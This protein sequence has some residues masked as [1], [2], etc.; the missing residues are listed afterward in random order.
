MSNQAHPI[1]RAKFHRVI[2]IA[3]LTLLLVGACKKPGSSQELKTDQDKTLYA[4]GLV[5]GRNV[6]PFNLTPEELT[7]IKMGMEDAIAKKEPKVKLEEFGP[8]IQELAVSRASATAEKQK[9][10]SE[11]FLAQAA[12]EDGAQSKPSG[13]IFKPL[14]EGSGASPTPTSTVKVHYEGKLI[15]GTAFDSSI[16]RGEPA[17]FPL[18]Q[19]IPCWTEAL[20]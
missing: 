9:K 12:K 4:L 6:S 1:P 5:L 19:V 15:D 2:I 3:S 16:A 17:E 11:G 8:K 7:F 10:D 18:N 20:Q 14:T 13:L